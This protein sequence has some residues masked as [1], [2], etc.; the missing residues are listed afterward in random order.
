MFQPDEK[1]AKPGDVIEFIREDK[2]LKGKVLHSQLK[3]S[4]IVDISSLNDMTALEVNHP[5]TVVGH[6]KYRIIQS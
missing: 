2:L 4:S 6:D 1:K 5:N 3:N